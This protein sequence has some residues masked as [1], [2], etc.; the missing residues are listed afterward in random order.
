MLIAG[1]WLCCVSGLVFCGGLCWVVVRLCCWLRL[2][3]FVAVVRFG[4]CWWFCLL[5]LIAGC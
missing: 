5:W 2:C 4:V 3:G 1:F